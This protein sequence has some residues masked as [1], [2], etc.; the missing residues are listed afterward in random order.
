[1]EDCRKKKVF[2][3]LKKYSMRS[4]IFKAL[5]R[6]QLKKE[7]FKTNKHKM[8]NNHAK[9][10]NSRAL[11]RTVFHHHKYFRNHTENRA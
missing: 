3:Q 8:H 5:F 6:N 2:L 10:A 7:F 9:Q 1:M 4:P 11:H